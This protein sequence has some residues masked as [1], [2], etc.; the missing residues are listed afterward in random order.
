M[1][2][3]EELF[4]HYA[5]VFGLPAYE[6]EYRFCPDRKWRADFAFV[7]HKVIVEC[8][9]GVW[10][11]HGGRH[12]GDADREKLNAAAALGWRVLRF[13]PTM[14]RDNPAE[15]ISKVREAMGR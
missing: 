8:D 13:S 6:R 1:S 15:C 3:A 11:V 10:T 12:G 9:G 2:D 5:R 7:E 14:L 4:V